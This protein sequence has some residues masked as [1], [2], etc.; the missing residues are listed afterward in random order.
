MV[1]GDGRRNDEKTR[2]KEEE[3]K[4]RKGR[5]PF[6]EEKV[7]LFVSSSHLILFTFTFEPLQKKRRSLNMLLLYQILSLT[8]SLTHTSSTKLKLFRLLAKKKE[9]VSR[10]RKYLLQ[11]PNFLWLILWATLTIVQCL[12]KSDQITVVSF[13]AFFLTKIF[14][15]PV[16]FKSKNPKCWI[17]GEILCCYFVRTDYLKI[18]T[19][20]QLS[21]GWSNRIKVGHI[22]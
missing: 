16:L 8:P 11:N 4:A 13:W 20:L 17:E 21:D 10:G 7:S 1:K 2:R 12:Q 15:N 9:K 6:W 3:E 19:Q 5:F 14:Y 22:I 18:L